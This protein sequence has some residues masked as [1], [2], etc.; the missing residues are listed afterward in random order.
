MARCLRQ[1]DEVVEHGVGPV[2]RV[3]PEHRVVERSGRGRQ[4][5]VAVVLAVDPQDVEVGREPLDLAQEVLG[6]ESALPQLVRQ[7]VGRRRQADARLDELTQQRRHEHRVTGIV[8]LELVDADEAIALER[9]DGRAEAQRTDEV[10]VLDERAEALRPGDGVPQ[11]GEEVGLADPE[12]AVEVDAGTPLR[13]GRPAEDRAAGRRLGDARREGPQRGE[14][15]RLGGLPRIREIGVEADVGEVGR[16]DEL[17]HEIGHRQR[18]MT[19]GQRLGHGRE[20]I[21]ATISR[22]VASTP[23]RRPTSTTRPP[24]GVRLPRS[25]ALGA[26]QHGL[27][28]RRDD[29]GARRQLAVDQ[30]PGRPARLPAGPTRRRCRPRRC[31]HD[32]RRGLPAVR[33][34]RR[35]RDP[36]PG[37]PPEPADV[38]RAHGRACPPDRLHDRC[39]RLREH[40]RGSAT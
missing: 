23:P 37:P 4:P 16:R 27:D 2:R 29:A 32:P 17:V 10:G 13:R 18:G 15:C 28:P 31:R 1:G 24:G 39:A 36:Q 33:A 38:R 26:R 9:L 20:P 34:H 6:R 22:C 35:H 14:R 5:A 11:R 3:G 40:P 30:H 7:R 12:A 8:E 25:P 19:R 21:H